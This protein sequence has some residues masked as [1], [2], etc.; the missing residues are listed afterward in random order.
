MWHVLP[1]E[2]WIDGVVKF[3]NDNQLKPENSKFMMAFFSSM[4]TEFVEYFQRS[5]NQ[6]SSFSGYNFHIFTPL[7][8]EDK[9]IPD[10][11]WRYMRSEFNSL[12]IPIKTEP[13]FVFFNLD[14]Y[15]H[16]RY[17]PTFFAG[18]ECNTFNDFP[19]KLKNAIDKSIEVSDTRHLADKL[20]EIFLS[21]NIIPF[22]SV[23]HQLKETIAQQLPQA[24][25]FISHSSVDKSFVKKLEAEL[26]KDKSLKF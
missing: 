5:K 15:R 11:H 17:E 13:T 14:K 16:D 12:G 2:K 25:I 1:T 24:K 22:D 20:S 4:D 21:R 18:F 23:N 10:E 8:Y 9:V 3:I 26:S 6:I 19:R 7:I